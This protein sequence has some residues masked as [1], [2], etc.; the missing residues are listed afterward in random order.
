MRSKSNRGKV[1]SLPFRWNRWT[2]GC[3]AGP[4]ETDAPSDCD[5]YASG[6]RRSGNSGWGT[7]DCSA[8]SA[9]FGTDGKPVNP[10]KKCN[11]LKLKFDY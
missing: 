11:F 1:Y 7:S 3:T 5:C 4:C 6:R 10:F 9:P 2:G 8:Q